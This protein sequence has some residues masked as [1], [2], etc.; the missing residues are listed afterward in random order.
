MDTEL[1]NNDMT[2]T[3]TQWI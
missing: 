3:C 2:K 1:Q